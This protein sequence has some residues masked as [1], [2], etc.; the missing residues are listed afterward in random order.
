MNRQM[1]ARNMILTLKNS[2]A[3]NKNNMQDQI[4]GKFNKMKYMAKG[5][6]C[7]LMIFSNNIN[8]NPVK[9]KNR[10][11]NLM[12]KSW[13][14]IICWIIL[15]INYCERINSSNNRTQ[16]LHLM[17]RTYQNT[18]SKSLRIKDYRLSMRLSLILT[19]TYKIMLLKIRN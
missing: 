13:G 14:M 8:N 2:I 17:H 12:M 19:Q 16:N 3:K 7:Y 6:W 9:N 10:E 5:K 18:Y 15:E 1:K 11:A 4:V